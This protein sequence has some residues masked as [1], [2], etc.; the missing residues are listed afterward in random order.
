MWDRTSILDLPRVT[1]A[2]PHDQSTA[3][4]GAKPGGL[5]K[6]RSDGPK[7]AER[8][9]PGPSFCPLIAFDKQRVLSIQLGSMKLLNRVYITVGETNATC[10]VR[11]LELTLTYVH[12]QLGD[13][14]E[15]RRRHRR[16]KRAV[17]LRS[18]T[19]MYTQSKACPRSVIPRRTGKRNIMFN[20][21]FL[22]CV[23][24]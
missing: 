24:L 17:D 3:V 7:D 16:L 4:C 1:Q 19:D 15:W 12:N 2:G 22:K 14:S 10:M 8:T 23:F 9:G 6:F 11:V 18:S 5:V 21:C 13:R 20:I